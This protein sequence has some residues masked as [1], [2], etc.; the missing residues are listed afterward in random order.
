M[1]FYWIVV[2]F[3][4]QFWFQF[5]YG[6]IYFLVVND[7]WRCAS[8]QNLLRTEKW[9]V[10]FPSLQ[11]HEKVVF[12]FRVFECV[13]VGRFLSRFENL[14]PQFSYFSFFLLLTH[15]HSVCCN[16]HPMN[17]ISCVVFQVTHKREIVIDVCWVPI[18]D[19]CTLKRVSALIVCVYECVVW[20]LNIFTI[21]KTPHRRFASI[22]HFGQ[23]AWWKIK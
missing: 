13:V 9:R 12:L 14:W 3:R 23:I 21:I 17:D 4:H 5:C 19:L 18:V 20:C 11:L 22:F 7:V 15:W 2:F 10:F 8:R 6:I 1:K 16:A